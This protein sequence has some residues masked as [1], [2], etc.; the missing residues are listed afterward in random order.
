MSE[1]EQEGEAIHP[2][3]FSSG[4]K[5]TQNQAEAVECGEVEVPRSA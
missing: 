4:K 5:S 1:N 2:P 3:D